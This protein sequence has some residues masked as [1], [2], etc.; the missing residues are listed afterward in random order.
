M[1]I[2]YQEK[3]KASRP[4]ALGLSIKPAHLSSTASL[5]HNT[6]PRHTIDAILGLGSR[7]SPTAHLQDNSARN[8]NESSVFLVLLGA[9]KFI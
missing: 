1:L 2:S 6:G 8:E 4:R 3:P 9:W 5:Q 7:T